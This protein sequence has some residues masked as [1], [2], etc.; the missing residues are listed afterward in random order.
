MKISGQST[1]ID[2]P[3]YFHLAYLS[4]S[5]TTTKLINDGISAAGL[6][7]L[8][9]GCVLSL[10]SLKINKFL[11][12]KGLMKNNILFKKAHIILLTVGM[13]FIISGIF[14]IP[15]KIKIIKE[16]KYNN[17]DLVTD[18]NIHMIS[19]MISKHLNANEPIPENILVLSTQWKLKEQ[20]VQDGWFNPMNL[21]KVTENGT[22]KYFII[23]AGKDQIYDTE[24]DIISEPVIPKKEN[25]Q[26]SSNAAI[27]F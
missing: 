19:D 12:S 20:F 24:D 16:V 1:I 8:I 2:K 10:V 22:T 26:E 15:Q 27:S 14:T 4:A 25:S 6:S 9:I 13:I 17:P 5:T 7:A 18:L 11:N 3:N 23:S 21:K